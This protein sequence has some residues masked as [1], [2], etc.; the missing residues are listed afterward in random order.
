MTTTAERTGPDQ[1]SDVARPV[2]LE[3][4]EALC[5]A[6]ADARVTYCHWKSNEALDRSL[7]GDNDLDLLVE[8]ADQA[9]FLEV[10][11]R[12]GFKEARLPRSREV[13][14][15]SHYYG[16]DRPSG[17]LVHV[18]AHFRLVLGDDTTKNF[19]LPVEAA[20]L[21][22]RSQDGLLPVPAPEHELAVLVLRMVLKHSTWDAQLQR[23][24]TLCRQREEG[25]GVAAAPYRLGAG[26]RLRRDPPSFPRRRVARRVAARSSRGCSRFERDAGSGRGWSGRWTPVPAGRA[27]GHRAARG[28][29]GHLAASTVTSRAGRPA[30]GWSAG[31]RS[32]RSWGATVPG[33]ARPSRRRPAGCPGPSRW[34]ACTSG[35]RPSPLATVAVKV[36]LAVGRRAGLF[37]DLAA[38][39]VPPAD[40]SVR[41]GSCGTCVRRA[42][43]A[44]PTSAPDAWPQGAGWSSAT[45]FPLAQLRTMDGP[46]TL[47]FRDRP[48]PEP[49]G[50]VR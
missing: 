44:A 11:A 42:T 33:R 26:R 27:K 18:H 32:W 6:L 37:P 47:A 48:G 20:Y 12:L 36:A 22:S 3:L 4:V 38:P 10:L 30:S 16:L 7:S 19:W 2:T 49:P 45:A 35:D 14:A 24:G 28:A 39:T 13:P 9:R 5:A 8:R 25:A 17:R 43:A 1:G 21:D 50:Q 46:R 41:A 15:V 40:P 34:S 31:A 29:S 23:R